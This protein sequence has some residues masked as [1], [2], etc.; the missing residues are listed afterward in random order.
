MEKR[1]ED[2]TLYHFLDRHFG[3]ASP[4]IS[5]GWQIIA[6]TLRIFLASQG[7]KKGRTLTVTLRTPNTTSVPNKTEKDRKFVFDLLERWNLLA[8]PPTKADLI[9]VIE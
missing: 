5:G 4:L 2:E 6:V 7:D 9:K 1:G 8:P 3:T